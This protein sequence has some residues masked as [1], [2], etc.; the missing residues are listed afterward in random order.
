MEAA[1]NPFTVLVFSKTAGY[2]HDSI[3]AGIRAIKELGGASTQAFRVDASEDAALISADNLAR[4]EVVVFLQTSGNFLSQEQLSGLR[5]FVR[6]GGGFVGIHCAASGLRGDPWYG[7]LIGAVFTGHPVPQAGIVAVENRDHAIVS[8]L[9]AQWNW[10]DEWYNFSANP[11]DSVTV[12]LSIDEKCYEG[13]KMGEDHPLAWCREFDGGRT[14]YTS[15]GHFDEA[16]E[17]K[18]FR[19]HLLNGILWVAGRVTSI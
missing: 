10:F 6:G 12:L 3:P 14:F 11:R 16:Y 13:G 19:S 9:P 2:R 8:G 15:L 4:Y 17:D 5:S 1:N 18:E 7:E